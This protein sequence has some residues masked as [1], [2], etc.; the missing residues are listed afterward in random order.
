MERAVPAMIFAA[1]STSLAFRSGSFF[2]AIWRT[3]ASV[4][5]PTLVRFGSPEPFSMPMAWRIRTAAG[6]VLVTNVNERSSLTVMTTGIVVP[7]SFA[8]WAL[9]ALT[10]SMML[11]PC[12]PSAGPTGGAGEACPPGACSLIVVSTFFAISAFACQARCSFVGLA[13]R[14][15]GAARRAH[16]DVAA[17]VQQPVDPS[18][19]ER[20]RLVRGADEPGHAG[21]AL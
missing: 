19:R 13:D 3:W 7:M 21:R 10:N 12:W 15:L 5:V 4:M 18:L 16:R 8:V 6:G 20:D 17:A 11:M 1:W 9:N 2:S 14:E